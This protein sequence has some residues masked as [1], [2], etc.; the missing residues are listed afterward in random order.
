[1]KELLC[2]TH[3]RRS[4]LR[5][6]D[7]FIFGK[8]TTNAGTRTHEKNKSQGQVKKQTCEMHRFRSRKKNP[9]YFPFARQ[10]SLDIRGCF[11]FWRMNCMLSGHVHTLRHIE[12][13]EFCR[14]TGDKLL[15]ILHAIQSPE[16]ET[17]SYTQLQLWKR[18]SVT[19]DLYITVQHNHA[20]FRRKHQP[21]EMARSACC[22]PG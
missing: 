10:C 22:I 1:M 2:T 3:S 14:Y 17:S 19:T 8:T 16:V 21:C 12:L 4:Q 5:G 9:N 7:M 20:A 18:I 15:M 13:T 11:N 6:H